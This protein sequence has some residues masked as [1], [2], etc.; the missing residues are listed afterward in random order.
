[1]TNLNILE[2]RQKEDL[3]GGLLGRLGWG[4]SRLLAFSLGV[5]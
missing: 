4:L 2:K 1:M 5:G 3:V